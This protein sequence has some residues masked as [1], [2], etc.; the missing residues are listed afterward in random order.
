MIDFLREMTHVRI[1]YG[2]PSTRKCTG[3]PS[4]CYSWL[5]K[6]FSKP[7]LP[8]PAQIALLKARGLA[9]TDDGFSYAKVR[10]TTWASVVVR[11]YGFVVLSG[12]RV[13]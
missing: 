6:P 9:I 12:K 7:Y 10:K 2:R 8:V 4:L 1:Q 5:I 3:W 11:A 13:P